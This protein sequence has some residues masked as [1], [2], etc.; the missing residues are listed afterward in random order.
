M[1][2]SESIISWL[3]EFNPEEYWR[4]K[5]IDTELQS[6]HIESYSLVREPVQNVKKYISGKSIYTDHY[7]IQARLSG[8]TD[9]ERVENNGFGE[10]LENWVYENNRQGLFP[11]L[12]DAVVKNIAVTT[13]FYVWRTDNSSFVYKLTIAK[14]YEKERNV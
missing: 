13:P 10:A 11:A 3:R 6:S 1:T 5:K 12:E 2:V 4:M 9:T 14:K 8:N 7:T